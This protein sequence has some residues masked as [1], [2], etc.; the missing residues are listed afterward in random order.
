VSTLASFDRR[1]TV[2][3]V[4][5]ASKRAHNQAKLEGF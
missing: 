3:E 2:D 1:P 4:K 5:L